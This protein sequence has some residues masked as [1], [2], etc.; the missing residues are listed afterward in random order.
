MRTLLTFYFCS[1]QNIFFLFHYNWFTFC[2]CHHYITLLWLAGAIGGGGFKH[3]NFLTFFKL[4][5]CFFKSAACVTF[6]NSSLPL[7]YSLNIY[8]FYTYYINF[9]FISNSFCIL[10]FSYPF[11][12]HKCIQPVSCKLH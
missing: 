3:S 5:H 2:S 12:H 11:S 7:C 4:N 6:S 10:W 8:C 9:K 1:S